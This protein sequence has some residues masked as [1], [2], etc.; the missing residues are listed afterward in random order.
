MRKIIIASILL[1]GTFLMCS[2]NV[3]A[4]TP[5]DAVI[6]EFMANPE[7]SDT[8]K[9]WIEVKN[10]SGSSLSLEGWSINDGTNH[11]ISGVYVMP[12]DSVAIVCNSSDTL[13]NGGID[14]D[15]TANIIF[16]NTGDIIYIQDESDAIIDSVIYVE[17]DIEE[18]ASRYYNDGWQNESVLMY[19]DTDYGTPGFIPG[20]E[21]DDQ[22]GDLSGS[23]ELTLSNLSVILN[24]TTATV[25]FN[26][27][28][29][30]D[31]VV[32][33]GESVAYG[34]SVSTSIS[35]GDSSIDLN[36]LICDQTYHYRLQI[37]SAGEII[38]TVDDTFSVVCG[39]I[40][41]DSITMTKT[42]AKAN[43]DYLD[44]WQWTFD[45]TVW[46][47]TEDKLQM[48]FDE[49]ASGVN[50]ISSA[51]NIRFSVD[52]GASWLTV[53]ADSSYSDL[54]DISDND[55]VADGTQVQIIVEMKVPSGTMVGGYTSQYGIRTE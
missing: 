36:N 23:V 14:C 16:A 49:W 28:A 50:A 15:Y 11:P 25:S 55:T 19:N 53:T 29:D 9:E 37:N 24:Q 51:D 26:L 52:G 17:S 21:I 10:V 33:Y 1:T 54:S 6:T 3:T 27:N 30:S 8:D 44:G 22:A 34:E 39:S 2:S 35:A 13:V 4:A 48:R 42:S 45:I 41:I 47:E 46:D 43:N 32:D 20:E 31:V 12:N 40:D 38:E 7:G 18:G 5:G